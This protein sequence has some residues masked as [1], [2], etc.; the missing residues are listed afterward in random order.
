MVF[1]DKSTETIKIGNYAHGR[2]KYRADIQIMEREKYPESRPTIDGNKL[3]NV[4]RDIIKN[5]RL[6]DTVLQQLQND[7]RKK[8]EKRHI[9]S[10]SS[11]VNDDMQDFKMHP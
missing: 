5:K 9:I 7:I 2:L 4:R 8:A 1:G 11:T 6:E 10:G 3:A